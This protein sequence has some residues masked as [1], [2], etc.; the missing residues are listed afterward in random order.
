MENSPQNIRG[1]T[2]IFTA[3]RCCAEAFR[4][5]T[6]KRKL[7]CDDSERAERERE[8]VLH[9]RRRCT[10]FHRQAS[11]HDATG[12]QT[13][14]ASRRVTSSP[15]SVSGG[16]WRPDGGVRVA[17]FSKRLCRRVADRLFIISEQALHV[18]D[19]SL[20]VTYSGDTLRNA[21]NN[22][23]Y[24]WF[25]VWTRRIIQLAHT[26]VIPPP[27]AAILATVYLFRDPSGSTT[28]LWLLWNTNRQHH[29]MDWYFLSPVAPP[30]S[31]C[32]R[33]GPIISPV[34]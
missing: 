19:K 6:N 2:D 20:S 8:R 30:R 32:H 28:G 33:P 1:Y 25:S 11:R 22:N 5:T 16:I 9:V 21:N 10:D 14:L 23:V 29:A 27:A 13:P 17:W 12:N 4:A 26:I 3:Q 18:G 24:T 15:I 7:Q 31:N 34:A